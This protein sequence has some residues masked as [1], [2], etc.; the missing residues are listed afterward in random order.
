MIWFICPLLTLITVKKSSVEHHWKSDWKPL[1]LYL[2]NTLFQMYYLCSTCKKQSSEPQD[3][4][5]YMK[6]FILNVTER[7]LK[8]L[9]LT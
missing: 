5:G 2:G 3:G 9:Y 7:S 4:N 1:A 8:L 6:G